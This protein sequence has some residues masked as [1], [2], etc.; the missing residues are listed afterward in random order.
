M[1]DLPFKF[2]LVLPELEHRYRWHRFYE[3]ADDEVP[4]AKFGTLLS[5]DQRTYRIDLEYRFF[6]S[7]SLHWTN[8]HVRGL[9]AEVFQQKLVKLRQGSTVIMFWSN[10][11]YWLDDDKAKHNMEVWSGEPSEPRTL[12]RGILGR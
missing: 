11:L 1:S 8:T 5:D 3:R 12:W 2:L 9:V 6:K 7:S 4:G 10:N